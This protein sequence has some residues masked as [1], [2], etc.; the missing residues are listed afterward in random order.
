MLRAM[1]LIMIIMAGIRA[2]V[3]EVG[4]IPNSINIMVQTIIIIGWKIKIGK[5]SIIKTSTRR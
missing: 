4:L 1:G 2:V 5:L 3:G